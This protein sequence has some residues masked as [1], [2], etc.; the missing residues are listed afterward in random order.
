MTSDQLQRVN[1]MRGMWTG[2]Q[3]DKVSDAQLLAR[4]D[5]Q[6]CLICGKAEHRANNCP[7]APSSRSLVLKSKKEN[8]NGSARV[9]RQ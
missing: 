9:G 3:L 1:S 8:P 5:Q 4:M 7:S 6:W 2:G